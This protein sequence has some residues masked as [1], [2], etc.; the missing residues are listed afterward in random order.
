M[1]DD[2]ITEHAFH[3]YGRNVA[4]LGGPASSELIPYAFEGGF[5]GWVAPK[6]DEEALQGEV[7]AITKQKRP[8]A[9]PPTQPFSQPSALG[10][11]VAGSWLA[12]RRGREAALRCIG[13][14]EAEHHVVQELLHASK[15]RSDY[16]PADFLAT[17]MK[18][19]SLHARVEMTCGELIDYEMGVLE[20]IPDPQPQVRA[21]LDLPLT[22]FLRTQVRIPAVLDTVS[23]NVDS[24]S[25]IAKLC[26][27]S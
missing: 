22:P 27:Y 4:V 2:G 10:G 19:G 5:A 16:A 1:H 8:V 25:G 21:L 12:N 11:I 24:E 17:I 9:A 7:V 26:C 6:I 3:Y 14:G 20:D 13:S 15:F 23:G 18:R